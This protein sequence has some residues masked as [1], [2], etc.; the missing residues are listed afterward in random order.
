MPFKRKLNLEIVIGLKV[1]IR[2][3]KKETL[4][5]LNIVELT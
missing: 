5:I 3:L 4:F 2:K 1:N